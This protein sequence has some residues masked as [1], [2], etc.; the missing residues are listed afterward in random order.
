MMHADTRRIRT[1]RALDL[2]SATVRTIGDSL[3]R[4]A[5]IALA[6]GPDDLPTG[7]GGVER[8]PSPERNPDVLG[9]RLRRGS[10]GGD[11]VFDDTDRELPSDR[12]FEGGDRPF[13]EGGAPVPSPLDPGGL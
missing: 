2:V 13:Q 11:E 5:R 4:H 9:E 3:E 6:V 8:E 12:D 10:P 1:L 7:P